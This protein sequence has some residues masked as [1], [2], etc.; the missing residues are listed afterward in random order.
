MAERIVE[1]AR[2]YRGEELD[3]MLTGL[4]EADLAIKTNVMD[5]EPALV[6]WLGEHL[7]AATALGG[8]SLPGVTG[9]EDPVGLDRERAAR[10]VEAQDPDQLLV[11]VQLAARHAQ[12]AGDGEEESLIGL[13][14]A[15]DG[16]EHARHQGPAAEAA[17]LDRS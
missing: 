5:E 16:V 1:A 13:G 11:D 6:A 3:A 7:L 15:E 4:F 8:G 17:G 14:I 2:R 9:L 12:R 10:A